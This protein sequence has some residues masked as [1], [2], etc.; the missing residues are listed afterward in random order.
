MESWKPIN[1]CEGYFISNHGR[2]KS[3]W[4]LKP[5]YKTLY[6]IDY[7][8]EGTILKY[9]TTI[10]GY[11]SVK[12]RQKHH[13]I[14]RLVALYFIENPNPMDYTLVDHIDRNKTNNHVSNLRWSNKR[15]NALNAKI[16]ID[17]KSGIP[18]IFYRQDRPHHPWMV[19]IK[20]PNKHTKSFAT[21]EE[22]IQYQNQHNSF[23]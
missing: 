17:N 7:N 8:T 14:H 10:H 1:E 4:K 13:L 18:G 6:V 21:K 2:V 9:L 23:T 3:Q 20:G 16:R 19:S 12:L 22:A 5:G 15:N 11:L